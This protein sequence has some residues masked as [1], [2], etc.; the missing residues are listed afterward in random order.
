MRNVKVFL[1]V[2][3]FSESQKT[4]Q[5]HIELIIRDTSKIDKKTP[6]TTDETLYELASIKQKINNQILKAI[7]ETAVDC[8]LYATNNKEEELVC[9]GFGKVE[10]NAFSS[11]PSFEEDKKNK[12]GLDVKKVT[13]R[14]K[15][16]KEN[17]IEYV[18]NPDTN[19][20]YDYNSYKSVMEGVGNLILVGKLV[21]KGNRQV[22]EKV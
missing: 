15:I 9:Y 21:R 6:V 13:W 5:K 16:I 4:D 18:L 1:Y 12:E 7:K 20:V 14:G 3:T 2:S 19:E 10:S 22:L 11:Y 17:G 8:N